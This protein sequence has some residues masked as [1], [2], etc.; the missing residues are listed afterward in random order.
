MSVYQVFF[1]T[2]NIEKLRD[3]LDV[4]GSPQ[5]LRIDHCEFSIDELQ[6]SDLT[7]LVHAKAI[8]AFNHVRY[9]VIVDHTC[10]GLVALKGLPGTGASQFWKCLGTDICNVVSK[11]GDNRAEITVALS[12]TDGRRIVQVQHK[13]KG[14]IAD[15]PRGHRNFDW[16]RVFIPK[17][18]TR[19]YAEM[20]PKEKNETSPRARAFL[21]LVKQIRKIT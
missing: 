18:E 10:L 14:A 12:F 20:T 13:Q 7:K 17:N 9:P 6:T 5:D 2:G 1:A 16:D 11:L 15:S 21:K 4:V 19:T 8:T 3:I